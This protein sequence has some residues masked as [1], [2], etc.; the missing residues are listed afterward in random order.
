LKASPSPRGPATSTGQVIGQLPLGQRDQVALAVPGAAAAGARAEER[1]RQRQVDALEDRH[2]PSEVLN[3]RAMGAQQ[4]ADDEVQDRL[5]ALGRPLEHR[6]QGLL[7]QIAHDHAEQPQHA[8]PAVGAAPD[9]LGDARLNRPPELP[10]HEDA[11]LLDPELELSAGQLHDVARSPKAAEIERDALTRREHE[12][13]QRHV[14]A[15]Q[16]ADELGEGSAGPQLLHV[17]D[18]QRGRLRRDPLDHPGQ[19]EGEALRDLVGGHRLLEGIQRGHVGL[20]EGLADRLGQQIDAQPDVVLAVRQR[21]EDGVGEPP[22]AAGPQLVQEGRLAVAAG[23]DDGRDLGGPPVGGA[24]ARDELR[25][26][27]D[28]G[29]VRHRGPVR[30]EVRT[31][32]PK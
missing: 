4:P 30:S 6:P 16:R 10:G 27:E 31:T 11:H 12:A 21:Q 9:P 19:D 8:R 29:L 26:L 5:V 28:R 23:R 13:E 22:R 7:L 24:E 17:V 20:G 1:R 2:D 14:A 15:E 25:A 18:E 32:G 3:L